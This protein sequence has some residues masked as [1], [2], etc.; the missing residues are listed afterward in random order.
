[1]RRRM[2]GN[3][4]GARPLGDRVRVSLS[5]GASLGP[6]VSWL[7]GQRAA[8]R[9][10]A[11]VFPDGRA[12]A[13]CDRAGAGR[14]RGGDRRSG[15]GRPAA[16]GRGS[17]GPSIRGCGSGRGTSALRVVALRGPPRGNPWSRRRRPEGRGRCTRD[18]GGR[19][20][21]R[22]GG[23][24]QRGSRAGPGELR[25]TF[26]AAGPHRASVAGRGESSGSVWMT[27]V[28][29]CAAVSAAGRR[30]RRTRPSRRSRPGGRRQNRKAGRAACAAAAAGARPT[31]AA[32]E[33]GRGARR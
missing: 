26:G 12:S 24:L 15:R 13:F 5:G 18:A 14:R 6:G 31:A 28:G 30:G 4:A 27:A 29:R 17:R 32:H 23:H 1:M 22:P 33:R 21:L 2:A 19:A 8:G 7:R 25:P 16:T 3:H 10:G 9:G 20:R 11:D